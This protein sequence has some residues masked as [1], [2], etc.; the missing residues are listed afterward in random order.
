MEHQV[1]WRWVKSPWESFLFLHLSSHHSLLLTHWGS[2]HWPPF[3]SLHWR[4]TQAPSWWILHPSETFLN[5]NSLHPFP[6]S[7]L[8]PC[9]PYLKKKKVFL[10]PPILPPR[11]S[12]LVLCSCGSVLF[13]HCSILWP[14]V[15]FSAWSGGRR[16]EANRSTLVS[17]GYEDWVSYLVWKSV[18]FLDVSSS[19]QAVRGCLEGPP[20]VPWKVTLGPHWHGSGRGECL[21]TLQNVIQ[22]EPR[23]QWVPGDEKIQTVFNRWKQAM[24]LRLYWDWSVLWLTCVCVCSCSFI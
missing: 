23:A 12:G 8:T 3:S 20:G 2:S 18:L 10:Q 19:L 21:E 7:Q 1:G 15:P 9:L 13:P 14:E 24:A 6:T 5:F 17:F 11:I 16:R 22:L 4:I